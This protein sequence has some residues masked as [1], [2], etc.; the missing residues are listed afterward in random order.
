MI[1]NQVKDILVFIEVRHD[2]VMDVSYQLLTQAHHLK[3]QYNAKGIDQEVV[4]LI[5]AK[6]TRAFVDDC[7][8]YG[9]DRVLVCDHENLAFPTS[10]YTSK[11]IT[12][13][14]N[15]YKPECVLI[16][17]T[18]VGR[19]IA[20]RIAIN[21]DTGLTAD[22]THIEV[23]PSE[24][25]NLLLVTRPAFGGNLYGTIV[26][27][28]F[29]PQMTT[30]RPDVFV[31][32][33]INNPKVD[34]E[35]IDVD[36]NQEAWIQVLDH[37]PKPVAKYDLKKANII[38]AAGRS[39]ENNLEL[40]EN[41]AKT[42]KASVAASRGLVETGKVTKDMQVGQTGVTVRPSIYIACGISGAVQHT[43]GMENAQTI[44]AINNDP[45]AAIFNI[46]TLGIVADAKEILP[47]IA[48]YIK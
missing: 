25:S 18:V 29:T 2:Q 47:K 15:E 8:M 16:G 6:D 19:D 22:A 23:D 11:V 37:T 20:P 10:Q 5:C 7:F 30:I 31:K 48:Q 46:A 4:A 33:K 44:I 9:A 42:L 43:A 39:M 35:R 3:N 28:D 41:V 34:P 40:I 26:C 14:I 38:V 21:V 13:V 36:L 45:H 24:E 1:M 12:Q 27:P 17:A 32:E